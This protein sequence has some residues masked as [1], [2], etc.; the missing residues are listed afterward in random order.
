M[1]KF[2]PVR[3]AIV[4]LLAIVSSPGEIA[5]H[6]PYICPGDYKQ[7]RQRAAELGAD[8]LLMPGRRIEPSKVSP[9]SARRSDTNERHSRD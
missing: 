1:L 3:N 9:I 4:P 6:L 5:A 2:A 7:L 8:T